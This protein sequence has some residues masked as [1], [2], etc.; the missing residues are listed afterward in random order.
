MINLVF[1]IIWVVLGFIGSGMY[2][3]DNQ[4][5]MPDCAENDWK[6]TVTIGY[7]F[8]FTG[9]VIFIIG[10]CIVRGKGLMYWPPT[11]HKKLRV[12]KALAE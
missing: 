12:M 3:Y 4:M 2:I 6:E 9:P 1:S 7:I 8:A 5:V 10:L 11:Y